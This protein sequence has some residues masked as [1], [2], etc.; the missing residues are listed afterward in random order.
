M[1]MR[2]F[3]DLQDVSQCVFWG[4]E[5][6]AVHTGRPIPFTHN[7]G[8]F[9]G[10]AMKVSAML[11]HSGFTILGNTDDIVDPPKSWKRFGLMAS[12]SEASPKQQKGRFRLQVSQHFWHLFF[13]W[14]P[15]RFTKAGDAIRFTLENRPPAASGAVNLAPDILIPYL[16]ITKMIDHPQRMTTAQ[17]MEEM[18]KQKIKDDYALTRWLAHMTQANNQ[19]SSLLHGLFA[20][21]FSEGRSGAAQKYKALMMRGGF[22]PNGI[23]LDKNMRQAI[24][25]FTALFGDSVLDTLLTA[26]RVEWTILDAVQAASE[27]LWTGE[28]ASAAKEK[29]QCQSM[30]GG[31]LS[32]ALWDYDRHLEY[33]G[34]VAP[35]SPS[36]LM[37]LWKKRS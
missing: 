32:I 34:S 6:F 18:K 14:N 2:K 12:A 29:T 3:A 11:A 9:D 33:L 7:A 1:N 21:W 36:D 20:F 30:I 23:A 24:N 26:D 35:P 17:I 27:R 15:K 19:T 4:S 8:Y 37:K 22:D 28:Y 25:A 5:G 10:D 16:Y 31:L 13:D